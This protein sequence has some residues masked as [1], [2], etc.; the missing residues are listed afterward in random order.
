[1]N[2]RSDRDDVWAVIP[3][4]REEKRIGEV[5]AA[6]RRHA[7]AVVVVDD[8][9]PDGTAAAG[10]AAGATILRHERNRGKGA[11]LRTGFE[12]VRRQGGRAVVCLDADGQHDPDEIP[13]FIEAYRRTGIPVLVG[14][15][16]AD[17][18]GMPFLRRCTNRFMS[19]LLSREMHQYVPDTQCGYRL[20][21]CEV[22]PFMAGRT[23]RFAAESEVLLLLAARGVRIG[24][25]RIRTIYRDER[26]KINPL[27]DTLRFF[28][29]LRD[30]RRGHCG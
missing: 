10:E 20:F 22:T 18:A 26:S 3:A 4:F 9:S 21:A 19:A 27:A 25:V 12:Y 1:M 13:K 14:N 2:E 8:G 24:S 17:P 5:V 11:A 23:D 15:R 7:A 28:R 29:M 6:A 16:M 30:W